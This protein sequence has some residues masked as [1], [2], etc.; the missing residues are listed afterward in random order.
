MPSSEAAAALTASLNRIYG[1]AVEV[2]YYDLGD[3]QAQARIDETIALPGADRLPLPIVLLDG[4][5]VAAGSL[6]L[7]RIVA[8]V[9][10][11][12]QRHTQG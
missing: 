6:D 2:A 7:L 5:I 4:A 12:F 3:P 8:A 9:A 11:A 10:Q 1:A